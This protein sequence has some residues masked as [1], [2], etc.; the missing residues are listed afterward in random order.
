MKKKG[1]QIKKNCVQVD[2][3]NYDIGSLSL[4]KNE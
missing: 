1:E 3:G 2:N 4:F